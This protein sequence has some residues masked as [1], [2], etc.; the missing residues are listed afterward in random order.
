MKLIV[1]DALGRIISRLVN[2]NLE[3]GT[4]A[5]DWDGSAFPSGIYFYTFLAEDYKETKRI[6]LLK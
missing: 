4:Y 6:V 2:Q 3:P 1:Y 5:V